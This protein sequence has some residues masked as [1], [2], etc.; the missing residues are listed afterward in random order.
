MRLVLISLD[1]CWAEDAQT[2]TALPNLGRLARGGVFCPNVQTVYPTLT[3]PIH[4]SIL[5]G[6]YPERHGIG[7]N[8]LYTDDAP[9][10]LRPWHWEAKDIKEPTLLTAAARA[11]RTT[12]A[13]LWP[14]TG[15]KRGKMMRLDKNEKPITYNFPEVM[16]F[17]WESQTRKVLR[18]GTWPWLIKC[19]L[20]Y[21]KKRVSS[22]QPYLDDYAALIA[23]ALIGKDFSLSAPE[24]SGDVHPS[25]RQMRRRMPDVTLLH[26]VDCDAM[27]H[28]HGVHSK[29]AEAALKRLDERVGR[30][31]LALSARGALKD[32][33][34]AVVSDHGQ[35]DVRETVAI[36]ELFRRDGVPAKAH[37]LG[38]GAYIHT[39]RVD[40]SRVRAH[41]EAHMAEYRL[42]KVYGREELQQMHAPGEIFLAVEP[43]RG[44]EILEEE[45]GHRHAANHGFGVHRPE[46]KTLL[47]LSGPCFKKN[48][49]LD[50]CDIVDIAPTLAR[51]VDLSLPDCQGRV[52]EEI[53]SD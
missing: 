28:E 29:E 31:M 25:A 42:E 53:F 11:G 32:T 46:A 21:G 27:R 24:F 41:L 48:A 30:V 22:S 13:I 20:L 44:V 1:A 23:T 34:V 8:E 43:E 35:M 26:L 16:A 18:Y 10:G 36:N 40:Y 39:D 49:V 45:D 51:A 19:E 50:A 47:W 7:H 12:A 38:M 2:L 4:A 17:P 14:T 6:C 52:L 5:T 3:Y 15:Q 9:A 37:T 33:V